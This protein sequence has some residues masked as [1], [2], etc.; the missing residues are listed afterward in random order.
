MNDIQ[1]G[2]YQEAF[3]GFRK[4]QKIQ[5]KNMELYIATGQ[6]QSGAHMATLF[7]RIPRHIFLTRCMHVKHMFMLFIKD[8][9]VP[10]FL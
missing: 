1:K 10:I 7:S 9:H 8:T 6:V 2:K 5:P 3:E 4:L